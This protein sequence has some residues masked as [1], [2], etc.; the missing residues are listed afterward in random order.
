MS[1][2]SLRR[3]S[4]HAPLRAVG[5]LVVG[6]VVATGCLM[7]APVAWGAAPTTDV[8]EVDDLFV[9]AASSA[10]N[11]CPFEVTY[12]NRGSF[13]ITTHVDADGNE[14]R[15]LGRSVGIVETYVANGK[16]ISSRSPGPAHLDV[17]SGTIVGTGNQRHFIVPGEGPILAQAGHFV[18]DATTGERLSVAGLDVPLD[19]RLCAALAP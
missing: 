15:L 18:I 1:G 10:E 16:Q 3:N 13:A 2:P 6:G 17:A 4:L 11:P 14:T 7:A 12:I 8:V 19:S 5:R 9:Y